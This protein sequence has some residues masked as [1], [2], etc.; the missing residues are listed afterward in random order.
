MTKPLNGFGVLLALALTAGGCAA[1]QAFRQAETQMRA[2]NLDE[3]VAAYRKAVKEAPDNANYK[4]AMSRAL[5]AASRAHLEKAKDFESK[6][7]LEAALG[8]YRQASDYDPSNRVATAKVAE[9]DRTI[10]ER[11]EASRPKPPIIAMR[12]R[13]R[14]ASAE[15]MLNPASREPLNIHF[16]NTSL[17]DILTFMSAST[18]INITYDRDV[19]DR[20]TTVQLDGVTLEQALNQIMQMNQLSYKV[21]SDRSIFVFQDTATKH[22]QYDEQV[23]RTFYLSHADATEVSQT[24]S[25]IIRLPGISV[26]PAIIANKTANTITV[27]ATSSVVGI[28]EKVIEQNDKP[29]AEIVIDVE[30]LEVDR[31][32][33]KNYGLNLSEYAL[34]TIFSPE[35]SPSAT[36]TTPTTPGTTPT[37]TAT[38]TST[39]PSGVRSPA[40]F[41]LNTIS[42]GVSTADFYL[43]VPTAIVRFLESDSRTKVIAKPQLRGAEGMKLSMKVGDKVPVISTSYTPI[44]T[45]GAGVNPLSSYNY[46]DVGVQVDMTPTVTIEGDVRIDLTVISSTRKAD[47]VIA[48][49]NI[50]SFGNREVTTRLRLRDGE[51]N[52][53]A[54]LLQESEQTGVTGFPGAIHLP[55]LKQLFSSNTSQIDQTDIV[56][57]LTPHIVRTHEISEN[58]LKPIY[59]GSQQNLGVGG[60]PPLI[61]PL[62]EAPPP[63]PAPAPVVPPAAAPGTPQPLPGAPAVMAP[64]GSSPVPGTVPVPPQPPAAAPPATVPPEPAAVAPTPAPPP[65]AEP[66]AVPTSSPGVGAAQVLITPPAPTLRVGGGP[67]TVPLSITNASR[68]S[69]ITLTLIYDPLKLR[70]RS[71]QEGSFMRT[72]GVSAGFSQQVT[73]NRIDITIT[74]VGDVTGA[75]GTGLL[76]AVLF[77]AIE[78]GTT[79]LTLSGSATGPGGTAMGLRFNPVTITLQ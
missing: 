45:G 49:I 78:A 30:I 68:L 61:A 1:G 74:R 7:Q 76:A 25:T 79:T 75:T 66:P 67:Y 72:G 46:Q 17:R 21:V 38:G 36:T 9:L 62:P 5:V 59:I 44:A 41:N 27:R 29:R 28:L 11:V 37:T 48:G 56:M 8:E 22:A 6:D 57:L 15:P 3:A 10:R 39:P 60:P 12:E 2:G 63:V 24:L 23:V 55:V 42:R 50:P 70:V 52:L 43:A 19:T 35:T 47:V 77:D 14:A 32:R 40:P 54:G 33:T 26:Q 58:D 20:L 51:S 64:P 69:T 16:N 31:V 71:V 13:A 53:L 18:G 34:G 73:G 4:I 65:A